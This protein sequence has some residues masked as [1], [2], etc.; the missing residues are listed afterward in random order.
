MTQH[1][2]SIL[3]EAAAN[4]RDKI[5][6]QTKGE[7]RYLALLSANAVAIA[8]RE[9]RVADQLAAEPDIDIEAIRNGAHDDDMALYEELKKRVA[10]RA[11]IADQ[12]SLSE[13]ERA[14][15]VDGDLP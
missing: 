15:Y 9:L 2:I 14:R 3:E 11:W 13:A 12:D 10:L 7:P 1:L 4:M 6:Q 5:A 8:A